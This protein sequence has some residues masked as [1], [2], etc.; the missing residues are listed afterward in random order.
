[1]SK[2]TISGVIALLLGIGGYVPC[3]YSA[4]SPYKT[5]AQ[6][7]EINQIEEYHPNL[8]ITG[9]YDKSLAA[10]CKNGIF[11]GRKQDDVIA[12]KG[13]P[14]ATQ[15]VGDKRFKKATDPEASDKVYEAYYFGPSCMQPIDPTGERSSLYEQSEACLNLNVWKNVNG[16]K[17]KPVLVFIHGGGWLQGGTADPLYNGQFF[18][19]H[20]PD[21]IL[22]TV[23]YRMGMMGI[24]NLSEFP[25]GKEYETSINNSIFDLVQSLKWIKEN[26][27]A[28]GGD[29]NNITIAGESAGGG[30]VSTLC[31]LPEAKGLFQKAIPMSGSVNQGNDME[32]T[33]ALPEALK[34][35]FGAK[36]VKD[37]QQIDFKTIQKYWDQNAIDLYSLIVR[38]GKIIPNDPFKLWEDGM[39]KDL[40]IMQGHTADEFRYFQAVFLGDE[41]MFDAVCQVWMD[42]D[43][44]LETE[45]FKTD[46]SQYKEALKNLGYSGKEI[47]SRYMDDKTLS[48][49]NT[50]QALEHAKNGG[51]SYSYTFEK[52]YD[53]PEYLGAAHAIDCYYMFGTFDGVDVKGTKEEVDLALEFQKM[54][55]NFAKTGD[56]STEKYAWPVYN[57]E[58][59]QKMMIGDNM[60]VE[61]NP[62]KE[63]VDAALK[64]MKSGKR[65]RYINGFAEQLPIVAERYPEV[66]QRYINGVLAAKQKVTEDIESKKNIH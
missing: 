17:E 40:I 1:M 62:E 18:A 58:T 24:M 22:V 56:P 60:R 30:A 46:L 37:L 53:Y 12:W 59:R 27:A 28:F 66:Y 14:F 65:F 7:Q 50:Y 39:S 2:L 9:E 41:E 51:I 44:S 64:M 49:G 23:T 32:E 43:E 31:T 45:E 33:L 11:V 55:A 34:K 63:R 54:I 19:Q 52:K 20:N 25:D 26:I 38:D 47:T 10:D 35:E 5:Q 4:V 6:W 13:I 15:P 42:T 3:G 57:N 16:A 21:V 29:P 61:T 48:I 36:T 8:E